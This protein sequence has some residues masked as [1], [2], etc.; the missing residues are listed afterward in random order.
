MTGPG[1]Y[2]R[3]LRGSLYYS[4]GL[5]GSLYDLELIPVGILELEHRRDPRP[6]QHVAGFD[7]AL[8]HGPV[9]SL[10]I[11]NDESDTRIG[12]SITVGDERHRSGCAGRGHGDPAEALVGSRVESLLESQPAGE[13]LPR[14]VLIADR[15]PDCGNVSDGGLIH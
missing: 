12:T 3:G 9:L 7:A 15:N 5:R 13:E 10:G 6:P 14:P 1:L 4:R 11:R 8:A 2:S